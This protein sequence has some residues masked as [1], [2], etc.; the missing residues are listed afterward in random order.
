MVR[1]Y[2][3]KC[4]RTNVIQAKKKRIMQNET[5]RKAHFM[6]SDIPCYIDA[7]LKYRSMQN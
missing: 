5:V 7:V 1:F 4:Y 2:V 3:L 6:K